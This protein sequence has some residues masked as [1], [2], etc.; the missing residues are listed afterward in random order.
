MRCVLCCQHVAFYGFCSAL[1]SVSSKAKNWKIFFALARIHI[2]FLYPKSPKPNKHFSPRCL[3]A[4]DL[5]HR[6][7]GFEDFGSL[8]PFFVLLPMRPMRCAF[9]LLGMCVREGYCFLS[10]GNFVLNVRKAVKNPEAM[11]LKEKPWT[12][13]T[14]VALKVSYFFFFLQLM[15]AT[16]FTTLTKYFIKIK[17]TANV[18]IVAV[19]V[20]TT[21]MAVV[22]PN[23]SA[24][25][26]RQMSTCLLL[27]V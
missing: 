11:F 4:Q 24:W 23:T 27:L 7:R 17:T 15:L 5:K 25:S 6:A 21:W 14:E 9:V 19:T 1:W 18:N 2:H 8:I 3:R 22:V 13:L 16:F 26:S 10:C 12:T 20:V